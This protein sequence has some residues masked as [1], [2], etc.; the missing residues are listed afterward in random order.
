MWGGGGGGGG[1]FPESKWIR[2]RRATDQIANCLKQSLSSA[3]V[4]LKVWSV[5]NRILPVSP[6][7]SSLFFF[8]FFFLTARQIIHSISL[9]VTENQLG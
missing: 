5:V 1:H 9:Y 7:L 4:T 6:L 8:F 3:A 2:D